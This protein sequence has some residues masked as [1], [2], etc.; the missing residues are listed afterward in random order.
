LSSI[1]AVLF[2]KCTRD[3]VKA[4]SGAIA[5]AGVMSVGIAVKIVMEG[6]LP[7]GSRPHASTVRGLGPWRSSDE[8]LDGNHDEAKYQQHYSHHD[9][10]FRACCSVHASVLLT[11]FGWSYVPH[12]NQMLTE[13]SKSCIL[14]FG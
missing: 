7:H 6:A 3:Q 12:D 5:Y 1:A 13:N 14:I 2:E 4:A 8:L 10:N 9:Y 11:G